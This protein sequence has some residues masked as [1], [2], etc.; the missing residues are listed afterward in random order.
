MRER[1]GGARQPLADAF[2]P[3]D[4]PAMAAICAGLEGKAERQKYPYPPDP[5]A[6]AAWICARLGG[7]NGYYGKPGPITIH[8]GLL[9]LRTM[10]H[11]WNLRGLG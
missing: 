10:L 6:W 1:D 5:V 3:A 4:Q 11:G 8:N 7:W 2:N 9:R